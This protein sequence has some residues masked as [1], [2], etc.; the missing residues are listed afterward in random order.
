MVL[1]IAGQ[2]HGHGQRASLLQHGVEHREL[3]G[4]VQRG[5]LPGAATGNQAIDAGG[6]VV[7]HQPAQGRQVDGAVGERRHE[8]NP[9]TLERRLSGILHGHS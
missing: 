5:C 3:F 8:R 1:V 9:D 6:L 4:L 2:T 7:A